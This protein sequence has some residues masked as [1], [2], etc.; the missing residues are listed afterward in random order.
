M[1]AMPL[2]G[3]CFSVGGDRMHPST[4]R[5]AASD[6]LPETFFFFTDLLILFVWPTAMRHDVLM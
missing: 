3:M 5:T 2:D 6:N 1:N 4:H